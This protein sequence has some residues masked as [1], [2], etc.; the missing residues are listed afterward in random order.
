MAHRFKTT[1][2]V[3]LANCVPFTLHVFEKELSDL[4]RLLELS[5]I[6]QE[7]WWNQPGHDDFGMSRSWLVEARRNWLMDFDWRKHEDR[8][9]RLPNFKITIL[10]GEL[11]DISIHF[12]ALFSSNI[13]ATPVILLHGWPGSFMEFLTPMELLVEKYTPEILPYHF[14]VPSLPDYG[15][16]GGPSQNV[17]MTLN[18]AARVMNKLM[19]EIGFKGYVAQGGDIGSMLARIM[20]I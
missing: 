20:S 5:K 10:D 7:T 1:S 11:G 16:S 18:Y 12:A 15:L 9:N 4:R 13:N 6:G 3:L 19:T 14:I 2:R 17:E 8:V